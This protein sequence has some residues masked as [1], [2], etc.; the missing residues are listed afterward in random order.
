MAVTIVE[1]TQ[2]FLARARQEDAAALAA[3]CTEARLAHQG[4][5]RRLRRTVALIGLEARG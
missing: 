4:L 2:I 5:A 3:R 1:R